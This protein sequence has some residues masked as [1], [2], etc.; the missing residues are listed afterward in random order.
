[1]T[2]NSPFFNSIFIHLMAGQCRG[3]TGR[4]RLLAVIETSFGTFEPFNKIV[5]GIFHDKLV[6]E[7]PAK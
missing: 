3:W 1:M 7:A 5:R 2:W 6:G 4:Q